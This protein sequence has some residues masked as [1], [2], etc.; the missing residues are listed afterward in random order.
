ML[1]CLII[2]DMTIGLLCSNETFECL[3]K[4]YHNKGQ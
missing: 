2:M 1:F 3:K 4:K